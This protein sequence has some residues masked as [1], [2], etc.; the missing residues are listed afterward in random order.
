[1]NANYYCFSRWLG[2]KNWE[3]DDATET[4]K[5]AKAWIKYCLATTGSKLHWEIV[6][7]GKIVWR[8]YER[9]I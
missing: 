8:S 9:E 1:M 3:S 7:R 5:E 6:H 2:D 4:F